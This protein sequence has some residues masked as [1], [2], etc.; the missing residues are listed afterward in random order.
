MAFKT[1]IRKGDDTNDKYRLAI[2]LLHLTIT[3]LA[4]YGTSAHITHHD[5][6]STIMTTKSL[7]AMVQQLANY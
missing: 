7:T 5:L 2:S 4:Y 3:A 6:L 1:L